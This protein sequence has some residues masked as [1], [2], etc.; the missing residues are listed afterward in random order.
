MKPNHLTTYLH[1]ECK[2]ELISSL[3]INHLLNNLRIILGSGCKF[4][5]LNHNT[6]IQIYKDWK[7]L[8]IDFSYEISKSSNYKNNIFYKKYEKYYKNY[9]NNKIYNVDINDQDNNIV[10]VKLTGDWSKRD[11]NQLKSS[12]IDIFHWEF[13]PEYKYCLCLSLFKEKNKIRFIK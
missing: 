10:I 8:M 6:T 7:V 1:T 9:K 12:I 4:I 11:I 5:T 2:Q 3:Q 13:V